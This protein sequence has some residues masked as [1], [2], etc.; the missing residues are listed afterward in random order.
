MAVAVAGR[1]GAFLVG[2]VV[3]AMQLLGT[4]LGFVGRVTCLKAPSDLLGKNFI[5]IAVAFDVLC[6]LI[7]VAGRFT[8]LPVVFDR[9]YALLALAATILF[10]VFLKRVAAYVQDSNVRE[11]C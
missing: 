9:A 3:I 8:T 5:Y 1:N 2:I 4:V 11:T 6:L 7:T 10:L